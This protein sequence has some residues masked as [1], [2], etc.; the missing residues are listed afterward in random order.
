MSGKQQSLLGELTPACPEMIELAGLVRTCADP[1]QPLFQHIR[2]GW[3][4]TLIANPV[5]GWG[6]RC[7]RTAEGLKASG[8]S[9]QEQT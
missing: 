6:D 3:P 9:P 1:D 7:P 5:L 4:G 2:K 8:C